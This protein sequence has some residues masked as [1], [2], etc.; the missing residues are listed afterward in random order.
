MSHTDVLVCECDQQQDLPFF[1]QAGHADPL[2]GCRCSSQ[3]RVM[4]R[5]I[6]VMNQISIRCNRIEHWVHLR[7]AGIRQAQYTDTW[8]C[9]LHRGSRLAPYTDITPPHPS[10]P[11][12]KPLPTPH[13]HHCNLNTD[14]RP[15]FPLFPQNW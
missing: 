10:R 9:Y 12:F 5:L 14:T 13:P 3:T 7:C 4:S 8:T 1:G 11:W 15:T 2:D 6:Q